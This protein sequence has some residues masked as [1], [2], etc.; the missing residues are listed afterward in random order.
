M[1]SEVF[2]PVLRSLCSV[3]LSTDRESIRFVVWRYIFVLSLEGLF[4]KVPEGLFGKVPEGLFGK[5]PE[6]LFGK[7]PEGLFEKVPEGLFGKVPEG[8]FR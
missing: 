2:S 1:S 8:L 7:V 6:G 5:V 4:G 3:L